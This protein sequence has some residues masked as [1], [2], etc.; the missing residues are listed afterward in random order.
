MIGFIE[1][2]FSISINHIQLTITHNQSLTEPFFL[3]CRGLAPFSCCDWLL[4]QSQGQSYFTTGDLPPI[5]SSLPTAIN[6][7]KP[8]T[9]CQNPYVTSRLMR[10]WVCR[11]QLL[12]GLASAVIARPESRETHDHILLCQIRDFTNLEGQVPAFISPSNGV[13][14]L[15]TPRH[16]VSFPSP[17]TT[18]RVTVEVF[19]P[20]FTG[21]DAVRCT[22]YVYL[23]RSEG[24]L[25]F[26]SRAS[27]IQRLFVAV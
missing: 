19:D 6:F 27:Q 9:C 18:H 7:F 26:T 5:G 21:D 20:A 17:P 16:W 23:S 8:N 4:S 15:Y 10:G 24:T 25:K 12:L 2:F 1:T 14:Q 13:A 11:L 3:D 22:R